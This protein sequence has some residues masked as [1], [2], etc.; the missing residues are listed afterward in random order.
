[1]KA[2]DLLLLNDGLIVLTV[3]A[4]AAKKCT[5]PS[6]RRELSNN[7]GHQQ[8]GGGLTA[9]APHGQGHEEDPDGHELSGR[10]RR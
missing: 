10:L 1:M 4:S 2:G 3:N 7:K 8:Q 5:P 6:F 9:P